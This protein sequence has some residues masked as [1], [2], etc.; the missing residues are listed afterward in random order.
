MDLI[1]D[2]FSKTCKD[3][4]AFWT[5][6]TGLTTVVLI[7]VAYRQLGGLAATSRS[8]F[9]FRLK[10]EFFTEKTRRLIFLIDTQS[11]RFVP[12]PAPHFTVE[13]R[14]EEAYRPVLDELKIEA[15]TISTYVIDYDLFGA[16]V[17]ETKR[18]ETI[19]FLW[20]HQE[21]YARFRCKHVAPVAMFR[22][23]IS[24]FQHRSD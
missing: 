15:K 20:R 9:I 1:T 5:M 14:N 2:F 18:S 24:L 21:I 4:T 11:L 22:D 7:W 3:P 8:D 10:I 19:Y 23:G 6:V 17:R 13:I 16:V 12:T